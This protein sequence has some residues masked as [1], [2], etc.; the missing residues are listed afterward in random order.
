MM[1]KQRHIWLICALVVL[2]TGGVR[3]EEKENVKEEGGESDTTS[4]DRRQVLHFSHGSPIQPY[5]PSPAFTV[6]PQQ[7]YSPYGVYPPHAP[8]AHLTPF[9]VYARP[10]GPLANSYNLGKSGAPAAHASIQPAYLGFANDLQHKP[11]RKTTITKAP[12]K[13]VIVSTTPEPR[14]TLAPGL[15]IFTQVTPAVTPAITV[16]KHST[17]YHT[18]VVPYGPAPAP[19]KGCP[20]YEECVPLV[21]CAPCFSDITKKQQLTPCT[22]YHGAVGV[23]CP[24]MKEKGKI[25]PQLFTQPAIEVPIY[26]F[27]NEQ[28]DQAARAGIWEIVERHN[29]EQALQERNIVINDRSQP[30]Y[31][32]L[33]FF[34]TSP[35]AIKLSRDALTNAESCDY[36]ATK[37]RL[38]PEQAGYGL[39]RF[40]VKD[41]IISDTC[42]EPPRCRKKEHFYRTVD[43]SCNN[44]D[45]PTWGQARTTFQR[46]LPPQYSD[47]LFRPRESRTGGAL[48][49]ARL[50]SIST[51][52]DVDSPS[53][54]LTL[55]VMQ[56]GQFID[57]DLA[58]TPI[59]RLSNDSGIRCCNEQ[60]RVIDAS[61][62][63]PS[64]FPIE[65][66]IDDPFYSKFNRRCMNFVRSMFAPR[67]QCNFGFAEQMNQITHYLDGSNI[68]GSG[69]EEAQNVRVGHGGLLKVQERGL[70]PPHHDAEECESA[71][72]GFACFLAGDNRV[73]E[74]I[75]LSVI[76]TVWMREHNRLARELA[77]LNPH[78]SDE[79]IYQEARRIVIA[80]YQHIIYN[81]WLPVV[82]GKEYMEVNG[83]LPHREGYSRDY[84][85]GL[86]A[87]IWNEFATVAFRF[88]HSLVQGMVK[89]FNK[90]GSKTEI[91]TLRD[92]FNN[93]KL[94]Y[95]PGKLDEFLTGLAL[96]P[97]QTMDNL[98][99]EDLTNHLFQTKEMP[100]GMD[101]VSLNLQR[102]RDHG[103]PP[104][105]DLRESCGLPRAT[106]FEDLLDVIPEKIVSAFKLL[107]A[108]VD[109]IDPFIAGISERHAEGAL[110]GPTFRC[111]VGDQFIRLKRGDRFFYDFSDMPTS[112]TEAQLY[113]IR[114]ASWARILCDN[115]DNIM[116]M[117]PL[118][119][120]QPKGINQRVSCEDY[121]IPRLDLAPWISVPEK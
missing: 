78:W 115:G 58:H 49:S 76:H 79:T 108:T 94:L 51:V 92:H 54:H 53:H 1:E 22:F 73:N 3:S 96:Q 57:H 39:Q 44:L 25:L 82:I 55:S 103:I 14:V 50:V 45:H 114:Q 63:H 33:Q 23:C 91:V 93:P 117:Q 40:S 11:P 62:R 71:Q 83:I 34:R 4:R 67:G 104:Y 59:F 10:V 97:I 116:F 35:L 26:P 42:P 77:R 119:F 60:S 95:T 36:L 70:L 84:D 48:P 52:I 101:L 121:A 37:F 69:E 61:F 41:T 113:E 65:I 9:A 118:A 80:E 31:I 105:N 38:T 47:G 12:L 99:S 109:D 102:G 21:A 81:E 85:K 18:P 15:S 72:E 27:T 106:T 28:L 43:G 19:T 5:A 17:G 66:P 89:L 7:Q 30:A 90:Q 2:A 110:L 13:T 56:W 68:Y 112:F 111:I 16:Y 120:L 46:I 8:T 20:A 98:V 29:L 87:A 88:G 24:A 107:Y 86:N 6:L 75:D 100:F 74:Q 32:H 64:C